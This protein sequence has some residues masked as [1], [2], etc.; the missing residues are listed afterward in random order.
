[1][2]THTVT[3]TATGEQHHVICE[4]APGADLLDK[5]C[6]H[7]NA[8]DMRKRLTPVQ[9]EF[10]PHTKQYMNGV[11]SSCS[12]TSDN[13][14]DEN[15]ISLLVWTL[16][17]WKEQSRRDLLL[18][19]TN[20]ETSAFFWG[21]AVGSSC[22]EQGGSWYSRVVVIA[23]RVTACLRE[24]PNKSAEECFNILRSELVPTVSTNDG[25]Y[26]Y[27]HENGV[28]SCMQHVAAAAKAGTYEETPMQAKPLCSN[29]SKP[30]DGT[31]RCSRCKVALYCDRDCQASAW[32][33]H[34]RLCQPL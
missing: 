5:D 32:K 29:C 33:K 3:N 20:G 25:L 26:V 6:D 16:K 4:A 19:D 31:K 13:S 34:K 10:H 7:G 15:V 17:F 24:H 2:P 11:F 22:D 14:G 8:F 30:V 21:V 9:A 27:M 23:S 18:R 1:M 28:C 12:S